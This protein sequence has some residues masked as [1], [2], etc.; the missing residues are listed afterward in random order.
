MD[1]VTW[2]WDVNLGVESCGVLVVGWRAPGLC[3]ATEGG[4]LLVAEGAS[5]VKGGPPDVQCLKTRGLT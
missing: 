1:D 2:R 3:P 5:E 4:V